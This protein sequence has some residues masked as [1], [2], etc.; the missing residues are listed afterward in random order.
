MG[1]GPTKIS[2]A[3]PDCPICNNMSQKFGPE[4]L[5]CVN[6]WIKKI[7]VSQKLGSFSVNQIQKVSEIVEQEWANKSKEKKKRE[8]QDYA[9]EGY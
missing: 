5:I 1:S 8:N 4:S 3:L 7:M 6:E 9:S 2:D